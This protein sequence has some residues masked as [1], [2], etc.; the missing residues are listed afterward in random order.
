MIFD[1]EEWARLA[2]QDRVAF[3][4]K[5]TATIR[6]AIAETAHSERELRML[7]GLQFRIDMLRRRHKS[8]LGACVAISN[9]L[10]QNVHQL[11]QIDINELY[12]QSQ[13]PPSLSESA[14][15]IPF[16]PKPK[17]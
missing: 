16:P 5:R 3:E 13:R 7:N 8:P 10:I 17:H 9:L 4:R 1:F 12:E 15:I 11:V 2:K 14:T 6:R